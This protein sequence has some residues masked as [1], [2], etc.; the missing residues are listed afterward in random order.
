MKKD[1]EIDFFELD[2]DVNF[3]ANRYFTYLTQCRGKLKV[4]FGD[5]R[6]SL[7]NSSDKRYDILI[8]DA[9]SGDSIPMHLITTEAIAQYRK[10]VSSDGIIL[11]HVSNRYLDLVPVL[12]ANAKAANGLSGLRFN[13]K[14]PDG[15]AAASL[16]FALTW[17]EGAFNKLVGELKWK[18]CDVIPIKHLRPWTDNY[19]NIV[20]VLKLKGLL[21]GIKE[22]QPFYW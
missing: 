11:F 9:F 1:Q 13:E 19:S 20:A 5:A 16:W 7:K 10:R 3:I 4:I 21:S 8:I 17:D 18:K 12:F 2:P 6:V 22:F 14:T 15:D